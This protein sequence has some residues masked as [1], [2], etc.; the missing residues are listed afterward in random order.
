V[1]WE[2]R[3]WKSSGGPCG[4]PELARS[5]LAVFLLDLQFPF[6]L[7]AQLGLFL[8]FA[9]AFVF[10]SRIAHGWGSLLH[11]K[12][13]ARPVWGSRSGAILKEQAMAEA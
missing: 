5:L 8:F 10:F 2:Q 12:W 3:Y 4:P 6:F 7:G 9:F 11:V 1:E 13:N